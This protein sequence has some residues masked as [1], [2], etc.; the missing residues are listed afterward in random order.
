MEN[1]FADIVNSQ[2]I[3]KTVKLSHSDA[4]AFYAALREKV[5]Q[6]IVA[7]ASGLTQ[8]AISH[9]AAAGER[10]GG[11]IRYPKVAAE[12]R[13]LGREAFIHKY[14]TPIIRERLRVASLETRARSPSAFEAEGVK[15]RANKDRGRHLIKDLEGGPDT[16]V[17]IQFD[18]GPKP[19][20]KWRLLEPTPG[21]PIAAAWRGDPKREER[22]FPTSSAARAA[23]QIRF[24]PSDADFETGAFDDATDDSYLFEALRANR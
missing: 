16:P 13:A 18:R 9:L 22:G 1:P 10:R 3:Y 2:L 8:G 12:Y 11:Q 4:C 23:C 6:P 14:V 24:G 19:G 17:E 21:D 15:P 7:R 20:W 5:S